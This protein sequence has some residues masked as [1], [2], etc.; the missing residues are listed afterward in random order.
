MGRDGNR[1]SPYTPHTAQET[2]T[3]LSAIGL[4]REEDL[5]DIPD[6]VT[7]DGTFDIPE[8]SEQDVRELCRD[9][10]SNNAEL[11]EFLGRGHYGH[12]QPSIVDDL[13]RRSEFLT[14]YTQYQP[15]IAQGFLQALFEYQSMFVELTGLDIVNCSI[16][17][18]GSALGEAATLASRVRESTG[19]QILVPEQMVDGRRSVLENYVAG[20]DLTVAEYPMTDGA[21][22]VPALEA[23]IDEDCLMVYVENPTVRG[24]VEPHVADIAALAEAH[25]ALTTLGTDPLALSL[26]EVPEALGVDVVIGDAATLGLPVSYGT[27]LG[28]F[29]TREAYLRQLPGRIIGV[30]DDETGT[31]SFT[32]TLQT[33]EQH[34]RRERAT[35]NICTNQAWIGLRTAMHLAWLGPDGLVD[36]ATTCVR[37][38]NTLAEALNDID[39]IEA[40]VH[41]RH[42]F[43]EFVAR[44]DRKAPAVAADL[45]DAGYAIHVIDDYLV[46]IAV[47]ERTAPATDDLVAAFEEAI[48]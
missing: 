40:P 44:T 5:F 16:Y 7:F 23:K 9:I 20:I 48:A 26:L 30:S 6:A 32:L 3:M 8:R 21:V 39:G 42:H 41:D 24:V 43:R 17:D 47:T 25:S 15:E 12:Y 36:L 1:G 33:R 4:D 2:E 27:G 13:S 34:I 37:S 10:L 22:D 45:E 18:A 31:R 14:S 35:S 38:A 29:A 19:N 28:L 46:Q 11:T